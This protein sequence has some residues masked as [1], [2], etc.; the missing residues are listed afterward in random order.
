MIFAS[1][2][3]DVTFELTRFTLLHLTMALLPRKV[4]LLLQLLVKDA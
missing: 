2:S 4:V 3:N 1:Q